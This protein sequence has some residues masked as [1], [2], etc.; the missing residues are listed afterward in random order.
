MVASRDYKLGKIAVFVQALLKN[1]FLS[2]DMAKISDCVSVSNIQRCMQAPNK[3]KRF[4]HPNSA[5]PETRIFVRDQG[6][7]EI[8]PQAYS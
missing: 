4:T 8:L 7:R 1:R 5:R 3:P 6:M 2:V